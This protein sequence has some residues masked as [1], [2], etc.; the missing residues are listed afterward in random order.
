MQQS[1]PGFARMPAG[2]GPGRADG[3]RK[4]CILR[5]DP[6]ILLQIARRRGRQTPGRDGMIVLTRWPARRNGSPPRGGRMAW[7][8]HP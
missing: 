2:A 8:M 6:P 4:V 3:Q 1:P 5:P 7:L